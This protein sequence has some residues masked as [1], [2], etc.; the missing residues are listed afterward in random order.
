MV[1]VSSL[2]CLPL[3]L[4]VSISL[5]GGLPTTLLV[6]VSLF[7]R[8]P[9]MLMVNIR[10]VGK[11]APP[12]VWP[13]SPRFDANGTDGMTYETLGDIQTDIIA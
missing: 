1:N 4:M 10:P 2:R 6:N 12:R 13:F 9:P 5:S 3:I 11:F 7:G 8:L